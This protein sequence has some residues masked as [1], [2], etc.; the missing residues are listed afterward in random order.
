[1]FGVHSSEGQAQKRVRE[2]ID[3]KK[4][5][6]PDSGWYQA[7]RAVEEWYDQMRHENGLDQKSAARRLLALKERVAK[8]TTEKRQ[9]KLHNIDLFV[10]VERARKG[11]PNDLTTF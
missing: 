11:E 10:Q 9:N 7:T 8:D 6:G 4:A 5:L 3:S 1:M 2:Y